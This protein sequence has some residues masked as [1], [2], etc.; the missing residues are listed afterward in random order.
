MAQSFSYWEQTSFLTGFDVLIIGSGIVGLSAAF[1]LKSQSPSMRIAIIESGFL[2]S[3][4]STK[5]AGF[6]CFGSVSEAMNELKISGEESFLQMVEMR[7]KGLSRLRKNLGDACINFE[8][9]RGY[10]I[11]KDSEEIFA[12][13]CIEQI[14]YLN[15]LIKPIIGKHDIYSVTNAKIAENGFSGVK[16]LIENKYEGMLDT[17]KMIGRLISIVA[18]LGVKIFNCCKVQ[19][20]TSDGVQHRIFTNQ[21]EFKARSIIVATNAFAKEL[22]PELEV[23]P[24]RG[25]VLITEPIPNLKVGGAFHYN[26]GYTYFRNID[27]RILLGGFRNLDFYGEQTSEPGLTDLIQTALERLL[28]ETILPG[29]RPKIEFRWSGVMGFGPEP[30]PIV[31]EIRPGVYCAVR[32]NGMGIAIGTLLGEEVADLVNF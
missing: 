9:S 32:C 23:I 12:V 27:N 18:G 1:R 13:E 25:Q 22:L 29:Q 4:A 26:R 20:F 24:G 3:G 14:D 11:F 8:P 21:G 10:E 15:N 5:N 7:W 30:R 31:K 16:Y 17:G 28:Y 6:A 2:P 19:Q